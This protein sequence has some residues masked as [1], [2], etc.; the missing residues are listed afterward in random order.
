[1]IVDKKSVGQRIKS[2][3]LSL[4]MTQEEFGSKLNP[5]ANKAVVS[6]WER[7]ESITTFPS[8]LSDIAFYGQISVDELLLGNMVK[9]NPLELFQ[10]PLDVRQYL[11]VGL[12]DEQINDL[13]DELDT[14]YNT[15]A[16]ILKRADIYVNMYE[17]PEKLLLNRYEVNQSGD[18]DG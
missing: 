2:I 10:Y 5:V 6:K 7:G 11:S 17:L 12:N 3:R 1:M 15:I 16:T 9:V 13:S 8:R 18:L 14:D 4:G